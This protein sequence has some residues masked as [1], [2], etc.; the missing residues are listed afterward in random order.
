VTS[1]RTSTPLYYAPLYPLLF[2]WPAFIFS[3]TQKTKKA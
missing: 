3:E 1:M 2:L